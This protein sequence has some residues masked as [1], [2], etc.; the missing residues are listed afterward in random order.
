MDF[1]NFSI[2]IERKYKK[3]PYFIRIFENSI[4]IFSRQKIRINLNMHIKLYIKIV[5]KRLTEKVV[6]W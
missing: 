5:E 3:H 4:R 1:E 6:F 2:N